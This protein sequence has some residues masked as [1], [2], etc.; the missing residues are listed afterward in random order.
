[1]RPDRQP[2]YFGTLTVLL[3]LIVCAG[4]AEIGARLAGVHVARVSAGAYL[5][6]AR[7]DPVL[8][9]RINPGI[10]RADE[11]P[12]AQ[13]T[14]LPDGSRTTGTPA[15]AKGDPIVVIGCSFA[16]GYGLPDNE[17][18]AWLLQQ[19]FPRRP[20]L[21]FGT[22]GYGTYQS[23]L[24]LNELIGERHIHPAAVIY[25][26]IP[27]HV[28]RNVLTFTMLD[29]FRAFGG[30]RFSPPHVELHGGELRMYPPFV[31]ANWP[32]EGSSAFMTLAHQ[33]ELRARLANRERDEERVTELL[34]T[35][36]KTAVEKEHA[37]FLVATLQDDLPPGKEAYQRIAASMREAG[38]EEIDVTYGGNETRPERL[39]VG[40]A[41]HPGPA[42]DEWWAE[43]LSAWVAK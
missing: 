6:W 43:K 20:I 22:P 33:T 5:G 9:W 15:E 25:G 24:L 12:H 1:M 31:V 32:L 26:F 41:G 8:G 39:R 4:I 35:R 28:P 2:I 42:V 17:T 16:E 11:P 19:R 37:S 29:A 7:R 3:T 23:L 13:M 10:W 21:N 14:F 18:F 36:M 38:I 27:L 34:L 30:Q 40:G